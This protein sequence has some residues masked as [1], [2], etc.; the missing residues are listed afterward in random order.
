MTAAR[1]VARAKRIADI[2]AQVAA[3]PKKYRRLWHDMQLAEIKVA[4]FPP[5]GWQ[6]RALQMQRRMADEEDGWI[7]NSIPPGEK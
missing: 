6:A 7:L 4:Y 5:I 2:H 1:A 3:R